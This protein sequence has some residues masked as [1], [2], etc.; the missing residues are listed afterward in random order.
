MHLR[1]RGETRQFFRKERGNCKNKVK[2]LT[3]KIGVKLGK[4]TLL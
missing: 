1:I 3:V 4:G 2:N